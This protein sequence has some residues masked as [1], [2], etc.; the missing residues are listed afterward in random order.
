[1]QVTEPVTWK[2]CERVYVRM[3]QLSREVGEVYLWL[4]FKV[5]VQGRDWE[6]SSVNCPPLETELF[7]S[8]PKYYTLFALRWG[9]LIVTS[10]GK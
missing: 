8:D 6:E 10:T 5:G 2:H 7:F 4:M 3:P 9:H 1:M